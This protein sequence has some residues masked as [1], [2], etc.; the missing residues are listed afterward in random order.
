M[1]PMKRRRKTFIYLFHCQTHLLDSL[2]IDFRLEVF[3]KNLEV[4]SILIQDHM[5]SHKS[6]D[7]VEE[8]PLE[9]FDVLERNR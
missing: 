9:S 2:R 3:D 5:C 1:T 8:F 4:E 7:D 6:F